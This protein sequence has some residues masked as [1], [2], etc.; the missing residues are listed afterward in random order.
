MFCNFYTNLYLSC[1][2]YVPRHCVYR[3]KHIFNKNIKNQVGNYPYPYSKIYWQLSFESILT[4]YLQYSIFTQLKSKYPVSYLCL[5]IKYWCFRSF[6]VFFCFWLVAKEV[7]L[8][9][10][11]LN[12]IFPQMLNKSTL[13]MNCF[14]RENATQRS[15]IASLLVALKPKVLFD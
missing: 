10:Q 6:I 1:M 4:T 2:I 3:N 14:W 12:C 5:R 7:N 13:L 9:T 15:I 11:T 8:T